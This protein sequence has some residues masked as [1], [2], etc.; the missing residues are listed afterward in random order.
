LIQVKARARVWRYRICHRLIE[1]GPEMDHSAHL[2]GIGSISEIGVIVS[3]FVVGLAGS[4]SHCAAMCGPFVLAQ[5]PVAGAKGAA[6]LMRG[7]LIPYHL[8]RVTTYTLLGAAAG[9]FG[10]IAQVSAHGRPVLG[11]FLLLGAVLFLVQAL[12]SLGL[13]PIASGGTGLSL[14]AGAAIA[15][16]ARP[17][18]LRRDGFAGYG[19]G[20]ALGF[21]PCGLLYGALAAAAGTGSALRGALAMAAFTASTVPAL[22]AIGC[23][24]AGI[25]Q[26]WRS[27][28]RTIVAP[29]QAINA[30][31][32][33]VFAVGGGL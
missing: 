29:L 13:I 12:R 15:R 5:V 22:V 3:L 19:L 2:L 24:G 20:V 31:V 11:V 27:L 28:A 33:T 25:A 23:A 6:M 1:I 16:V 8:G 17:L 32:L 21:L 7:A 30:A 10:G 18:L 14:S 26:R 9:G 4:L